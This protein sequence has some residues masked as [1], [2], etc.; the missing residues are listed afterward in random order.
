M[1]ASRG[2]A[3]IYG[4]IRPSDLATVKKVVSL[5]KRKGLRVGLHGTSLW[6][7]NYKD[8]DVL[9]IHPSSNLKGLEYFQFVLEKIGKMPRAKVLGVRGNAEV[10]LDVDVSLGQTVLHLS[11]V[12]LL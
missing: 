3:S 5:L 11:Y 1:N 7:R 6:N 8:I 2:V 4:K 10:G 12:L 9:V